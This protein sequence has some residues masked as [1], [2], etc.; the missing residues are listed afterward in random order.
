MTSFDLTDKRCVVTGGGSGIGRA[1]A[2]S[3]AKAGADIAVTGR[4]VELLHET[5]KACEA[6]G[7]R[8]V[9]FGCD[10]RDAGAVRTAF[11][12]IAAAMNGGI[13]VL[14]NNAGAGGPNACSEDGEDRW[15]EVVRTNLDGVF[16]CS[17]EALRRMPDG[18]RIINIS[19]VLGQFGVPGYTAYCA[20]KHGVIGFT[21]ALA[22]EVAARQITV[23]AI[24]PG[25]VDTAMAE[26]GM[27]DMAKGMGVSFEEARSVAMDG[28]PL[29][30]IL[31]PDEI[32]SLVVYLASAE[33]GGM[34]AQAV[35]LCGGQVMNG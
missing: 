30:R 31:R 35:S 29:G 18:G 17:R 15:D 26:A 12:D 14:V 9:A 34:T 10:V 25:W 28:V 8:A 3:L 32:G 21:K 1:T 16:F 24:C 20:S 6:E 7:R 11:E 5:V 22:L 19:S 2:I 33:A 4:R 23:N 27:K 13:D